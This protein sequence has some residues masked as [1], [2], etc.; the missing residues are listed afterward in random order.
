MKEKEGRVVQPH[1]MDAVIGSF[2]LP[3]LFQFVCLAV[4]DKLHDNLEEMFVCIDFFNNL[5]AEERVLQI[6]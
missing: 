4:A 2:D 5:I 3:H 1:C 6:D